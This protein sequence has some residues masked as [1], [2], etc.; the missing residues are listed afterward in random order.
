MR[1]NKPNQDFSQY[2]SA[3]AGGARAGV[4]RPVVAF[5]DLDRTLIDRYS[6]TAFA[7]QTIREGKM[8]PER[9]VRLGLMFLCYGLGRIDYD[10]MLR[11]TVKDIQGMPE[12]ELQKLSQDTYDLQLAECLYLEGVALVQQ[13]QALGH[14]IVMVTS[15][16]SYQAEPVA[17]VLGMN[18]VLSTKLEIIDGNVSGGAEPCFGSGKLAAASTYVESAGARITDAYFYTDSHDDLPLLEQVGNPVIVNGKA[19][20]KKIGRRRGWIQLEFQHTGR[21]EPVCLPRRTV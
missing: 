7:W 15:A 21:V 5:F 20:L 17:E 13:H 1:L 8:T 9:F 4:R 18:H 6:L 19:Q 10:E 16:T 11:A 3:L 14:E 2:L 12:A